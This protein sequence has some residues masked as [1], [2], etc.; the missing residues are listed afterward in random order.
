MVQFFLVSA[1]ERTT[2]S[3]FVP[4]ADNRRARTVAMSR[5]GNAL[6]L[7]AEEVAALPRDGLAARLAT[8]EREFR[9]AG[10]EFVIESVADLPLFLDRHFA[11]AAGR[12]GSRV[13]GRDYKSPFSPTYFANVSQR[14]LHR[15]EEFG[16]GHERLP[17]N[18]VGALDEIVVCDRV[19]QKPQ[20]T[21][22]FGRQDDPAGFRPLQMVEWRAFVHQFDL[23][24]RA[25]H[26]LHQR[27]IESR[28]AG[29]DR[30]AGLPLTDGQF[31]AETISERG[32]TSRSPR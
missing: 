23:V 11:A 9:A 32:P 18:P 22:P 2:V 4:P 29:R 31:A 13:R 27:I 1:A 17:E 12:L 8:I 3:R 7:S 15:L 28:E 20:L 16:S 25:K 14:S 6:G 19:A 21:P 26:P 5:T 10:A 24:E 30:L